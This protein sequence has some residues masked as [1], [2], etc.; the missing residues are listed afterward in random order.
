MDE[1]KG[2]CQCQKPFA[3]VCGGFFDGQTDTF[4]V[5]MFDYPQRAS[6]P[7]HWNLFFGQDATLWRFMTFS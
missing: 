3:F 1:D 4:D 2:E 5:G 7:N 6:C